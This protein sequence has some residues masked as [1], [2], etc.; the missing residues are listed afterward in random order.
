MSDREIAKARPVHALISTQVDCI[1]DPNVAW[2]DVDSATSSEI[3]GAGSDSD[4]SDTRADQEDEASNLDEALLVC[5]SVRDIH[6]LY[7]SSN[8]VAE[9]YR[10]VD[11]GHNVL[12]RF[13]NEHIKG[14]AV[15]TGH[16]GSSSYVTPL[17]ILSLVPRHSQHRIA[18][19]DSG[20]TKLGVDTIVTCMLD[21]R[22]PNTELV[23]SLVMSRALE[24]LDL[25]M[26]RN[27]INLPGFTT[28]TSVCDGKCEANSPVVLGYIKCCDTLST[29]ILEVAHD[30]WIYKVSTQCPK[31]R[32]RIPSGL[33]ATITTNG[34]VLWLSLWLSLSL[35]LL[36][37]FSLSL[38][39]VLLLYYCYCSGEDG[40]IGGGSEKTFMTDICKLLTKCFLL[41]TSAFL[42]KC[43]FFFLEIHHFI[44][45]SQIA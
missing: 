11:T 27:D 44:I 19:C 3:M 18:V 24:H 15:T 38:S 45:L 20:T 16:L 14:L 28:V 6:E 23:G 42:I 30:R 26:V 29:K 5:S 13:I 34:I 35:S 4:E 43:T 37:P 40:E 22:N 17:H 21:T 1:M 9:E 39:L 7:I 32:Y 25:C 36:L 31:S 33:G 2:G 10:S 8:S 41:F 12:C